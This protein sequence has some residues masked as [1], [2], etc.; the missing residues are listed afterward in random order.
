MHGQQNVKINVYNSTRG[1]GCTCN[2]DP[3]ENHTG[4]KQWM[5]N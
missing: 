2:S 1:V 4:N 3:E 5:I